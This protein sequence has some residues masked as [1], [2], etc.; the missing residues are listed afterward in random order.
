MEGA[1]KKRGRPAAKP[2]EKT[3]L[4]VD[5]EPAVPVGAETANG[6]GKRKAAP[7]EKVK[8][9]TVAKKVKSGAVVEPMPE[10][11]IVDA[12]PVVPTKGKAGVA[13]KGRPKKEATQESAITSKETAAP[14]PRKAASKA[15]VVAAKNGSDVAAEPDGKENGSPVEEAQ[16][17]QAKRNR[18]KPSY[19]EEESVDES[20]QYVPKPT[21]GRRKARETTEEKADEEVIPKKKPAAKRSNQTKEAVADSSAPAKPTARG[22]KKALVAETSTEDVAD[23]P[24]TKKQ[25]E[26]AS[27]SS[28]AAKPAARGRR[29]ALAPEETTQPNPSTNSS[30]PKAFKKMD[31]KSPVV[32]LKMC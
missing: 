11:A 22:R 29:K 3:P 15:A 2:K 19:K 7:A 32:L 20:D 4:H 27:T 13:K 8:K 10:E 5:S 23:Q 30:L 9:E 12:E 25:E 31:M 16:P 17:T 1:T 21:K 14:Q 26:T 6:K 18:G 28:A 24:A